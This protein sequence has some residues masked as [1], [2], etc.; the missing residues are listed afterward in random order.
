MIKQ[1]P[2][3]P[4]PPKAQVIT[5]NTR[6]STCADRF[7]VMI[8]IIVVIVFTLV[9]IGVAALHASQICLT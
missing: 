7:L 5:F 1:I 4:T 3:I 2:P 9:T 8:L 6:P